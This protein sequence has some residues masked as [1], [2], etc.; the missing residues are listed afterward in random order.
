MSPWALLSCFL[1][2]VSIKMY[3]ALM[4]GVSTD[5]VQTQGCVQELAFVVLLWGEATQECTAALECPLLTF[6]Q[7]RHLLHP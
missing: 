7:V 6:D 5:E 1:N 4:V 3:I 2:S